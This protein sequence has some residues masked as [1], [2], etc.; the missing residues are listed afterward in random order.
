[1]DRIKSVEALLRYIILAQG[2]PASKGLTYVLRVD[3]FDAKCQ[4]CAY[5]STHHFTQYPKSVSLLPFPL[6][7]H[8]HMPKWHQAIYT[9]I[10]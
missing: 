10:R 2:T 1:M 3:S 9:N 5:V 6:V 8:C 4:Y 7:E